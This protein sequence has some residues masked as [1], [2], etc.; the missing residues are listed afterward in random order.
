LVPSSSGDRLVDVAF[1][2]PHSGRVATRY[3][4]FHRT[5]SSVDT[6]VEPFSWPMYFAQGHYPTIRACYEETVEC[7]QAVAPLKPS[8]FCPWS[9]IQDVAGGI[10]QPSVFTS[11]RRP[12]LDAVKTLL[13][14]SF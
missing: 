2:A 14:C 9:E 8:A 12:G 13:R 6:D 11:K 4:E 3:I 5:A 7:R 10:C 1:S